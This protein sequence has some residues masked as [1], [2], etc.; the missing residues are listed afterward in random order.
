[1]VDAAALVRRARFHRVLALLAGAGAA[2]AQPPFGLL[3]GLF[4]YGL[5]F[6]L[7]DRPASPRPLRSAFFRGWLAG[8]AYFLLSLWWLA[9][10]FY[11]DAKAQ[12]WMAPFAVAGVAAGMAL[13]WGAACLAYRALA[14][15]GARRVILFAG[16]LAAFEWLRGHILTGFPWDLPGESWAAG[17]APSQAAALVGAYGLTWLTLAAFAAPVVAL[18]GQGGRIAAAGAV[19]LVASLFAFGSA[20]L[21]GVPAG[22]SDGPWIRLVQANVRQESKYDRRLFASIV[23]RYLSLSARPFAHPPAMIIW[24]EGAIP[25]ALE[26]YLAPGT[27]TRE[28]ILGLLR[29]GQ[30]LLVGGYHFGSDQGPGG[31]A[32]NSLAALRRTSGDLKLVGL[33][34]KFRLVPFG[35]FM[36]LDSLASRLGIKQFVHVGDGFSPGRRPRPL[37]L[38]GLPAVQPL[39]CYESLFPGFT[40]EGAARS[41][42]RAAWIVNVSNDSWFGT[43]SGPLQHLN[44]ASY[45]AIEEGLPMARATPTGISAMIDAFGRVVPGTRLGQGVAGVVDAP[46]P[47]AL[48]P[49]L[50]SRLGDLPFL[51]MLLISLLGAR[52]PR[53]SN[54]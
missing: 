10:P 4:G 44:I 37:R 34:D 49:T 40:R 22:A 53:F 13:F 48:A 18:E 52:R 9:E 35:E 15:P 1:M 5:T 3:P 14:G 17:S 31:R 33:Y 46:L 27:W 29:P 51:A 2:L 30:T 28:A 21:A 11:V 39:I 8:C 54:G 6:W 16:A 25:D 12:G 41:G 32:Y 38:P 23:E 45:R 50:F 36:P 42:V 7:V 24:P 43:G 19:A 26:S 20:R 47:P